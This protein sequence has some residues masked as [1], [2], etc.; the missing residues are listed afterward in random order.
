[1][2]Q[3]ETG[4]LAT[5]W[6]CRKQTEVPGRKGRI[7][8][9]L[10]AS[11]AR[12]GRGGCRHPEPW[13][14]SGLASWVPGI[15]KVKPETTGN[16]CSVFH[17]KNTVVRIYKNQLIDNRKKAKDTQLLKSKDSDEYKHTKAHIV[18]PET[19]S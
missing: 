7:W 12:E 3:E 16:T 9:L 8:G 5:G 19:Q 1:M 2:P 13:G 17:L 10:L 14:E 4:K 11:R 6:M 18:K 15:V